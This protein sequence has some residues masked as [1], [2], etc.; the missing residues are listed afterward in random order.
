M[1]FVPTLQRSFTINSRIL[2]RSP[3][4]HQRII[5]DQSNIS[6]LEL[7]LYVVP[8]TFHLIMG[9][10]SCP[11]APHD[12]LFYAREKPQIAIELLEASEELGLDQ[13]LDA[14]FLAL[15]QN[16]N[17]LKT[18]MIYVASMEPYQ[19][20]ES[21]DPRRWVELLEEEV[22]SFMVK[23]LP[24]QLDA[25]STNVKV[26]GDVMIG[27]IS[28]RGYM[29]SRT[30]PKHGLNDLAHAYAAL[31]QHLMIRCL[32]HPDL[33]AQDAIQRSYFAKSVL[34]IVSNMNQ[35]QH[36]QQQQHQH[37]H[38]QYQQQRQNN[39]SSSNNNN[40]MAVMKFE[41]G[42]DTVAIVRQTGLKKGCWDPKLYELHN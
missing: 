4:L 1:V 10:L 11:L 6:T 22:V 23:K 41:N 34:S 35:H 27:Q 33:R 31:P 17:Q 37:Q 42:R 21:E 25:F 24:I 15:K 20:L 36:Q 40:L 28:A 39:H 3:V 29:P 5:E 2:S 14:I 9:H 30:P 18:A 26:T 38:Q 16:L 12:I 19:P 13:L 32:E 8:E 7:D